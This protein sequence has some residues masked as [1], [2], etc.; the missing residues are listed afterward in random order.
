MLSEPSARILEFFVLNPRA[1]VHGFDLL[2]ETGISSGT[3]YP[4]LRHLAEQR[5]VLVSEWETANPT[6]GLPPRRFYRLNGVRAKAAR[7]LLAEYA[8]RRSTPTKGRSLPRPRSAR[9]A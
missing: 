8:E 4:A 2:R 9:L 3:L 6:P 7:E 5:E 1:R